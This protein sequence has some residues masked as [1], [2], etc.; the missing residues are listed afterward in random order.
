MGSIRGN[1]KLLY[2]PPLLLQHEAET[3]DEVEAGEEVEEEA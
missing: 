3:E 2:L 1:A